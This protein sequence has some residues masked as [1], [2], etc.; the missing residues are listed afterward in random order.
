MFNF[1]AFMVA[2]VLSVILTGY[3]YYQEKKEETDMTKMMVVFGVSMVI[4]YMVSNL[5]MDCNDDK[6]VMSNI[7]MGEPPF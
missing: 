1:G 5:I 2:L 6:Q 7:K 4:V 3:L